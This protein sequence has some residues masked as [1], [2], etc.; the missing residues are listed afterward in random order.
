MIVGIHGTCE[1]L[2]LMSLPMIMDE[3]VCLNAYLY[4]YFFINIIEIHTK[5]ILFRVTVHALY[6]S[7]FTFRSHF[8][9]ERKI[10]L[11]ME[12]FGLGHHLLCCMFIVLPESV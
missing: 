9:H 12:N 10:L 6:L 4:L 11:S 8:P 1:V 5:I 7:P 2:L 3:W